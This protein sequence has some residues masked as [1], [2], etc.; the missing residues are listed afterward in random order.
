M[1]SQIGLSQALMLL[2]SIPSRRRRGGR[3][4]PSSGGCGSRPAA[5]CPWHPK[6]SISPSWIVSS[7]STPSM[8]QRYPLIVELDRGLAELD[9]NYTLLQVK[10]K[11][12]ALRLYF[13]GAPEVVGAMQALVDRASEASK[14]IC[15][16]CGGPGVLMEG[17]LRAKTVCTSCG[18]A[19]GL[20]PVEGSR[21]E[22]HR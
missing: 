19:E 17:H 14:G 2:S 4:E 11:W 7:C 13:E 21:G 20:L 3:P 18:L 1:I 22:V 8:F 6:T 15:E 16:L 12:G 5:A 9:P 10:E